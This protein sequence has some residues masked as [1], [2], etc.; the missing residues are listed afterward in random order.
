MQIWSFL[1]G[2]LN[3]ATYRDAATTMLLT[4]EPCITISRSLADRQNVF[5]AITSLCCFA[6][7]VRSPR[8]GLSVLHRQKIP[9]Y[10][11]CPFSSGEGFCSCFSSSHPPFRAWAGVDLLGLLGPSSILNR[12]AFPPLW[13]KPPATETCMPMQ[14]KR[15]SQRSACMK[16]CRYRYPL[17][18]A[19]S[20]VRS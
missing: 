17:A 8:F 9:P 11:F 19:R 12:I 7:R 15:T 13:P 14:T 3:A 10:P 16:P 18:H 20:Q 6:A 1:I 2:G 5:L 4:S